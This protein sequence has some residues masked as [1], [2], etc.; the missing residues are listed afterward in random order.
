MLSNI[1]YTYT[2]VANLFPA[3]TNTLQTFCSWVSIFK[4]GLSNTYMIINKVGVE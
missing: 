4:I 3:V 2:V 1:K